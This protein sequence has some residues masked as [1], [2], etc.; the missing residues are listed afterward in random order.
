MKQNTKITIGVLALV[1]LVGLAYM[2]WPG[3][4]TTTDGRPAVQT[5]TVG[6]FTK[7]LGNTPFHVAH[8]FKWFS[9]H[10]VLKDVT[11]DY[12]NYND[13]PSISDAFG[14]GDLDVLFS[15]AIPQILCRAQGN[16]IRMV[17]MSASMN[18]DILVRTELPITTL[19]ELRGRPLAVLRG[20][21]SYFGLLKILQE[22]N[23]T[24]EDFDVRYLAVPEARTAF[25]TDRIDAWAVWA[26]YVEQQQA[27]GKGKVIASSRAPINSTIAVATP[28]IAQHP[29]LVRAFVEVIGRA[30]RWIPEH[31]PETQKII[32]DDF[33][34][35]VEVIAIALPKFDWLVEFNDEFLDDMQWKANFMAQSGA[36]RTDKP[37]N[38]REELLDLSWQP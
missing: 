18:Q 12:I 13:R 9:E 15:A 11:I 16:D 36:T 26:P 19:D 30:K 5:I 4:S 32:A 22:D 33:G 38:I 37:V 25:E 27:T 21:S 35:D 14:G 20:T 23:M 31:Q 8:H 2:L 34:L 10:P 28:F 24:L 6:T 3:G 29:A 7:S 1:V 17:A